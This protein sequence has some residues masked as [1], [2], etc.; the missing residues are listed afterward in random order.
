[1]IKHDHPNAEEEELNKGEGV[2]SKKSLKL[3]KTGKNLHD[4]NKIT[5]EN[6]NR[7]P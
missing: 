3:G 1:L 4:F 7:N 2:L 5:L 6:L